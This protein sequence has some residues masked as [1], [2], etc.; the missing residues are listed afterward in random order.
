MNNRSRIEV[1]M[2][3][4]YSVLTIRDSRLDDFEQAQEIRSEML[5]AL[6]AT[7]SARVIVDLCNVEYLTSVALMP[8]V[9]LSASARQREGRVVL[10]NTCE[11]VTNVLT[12]SQLIVEHRD[13]AKYLEMADNLESAIAMVQIQAER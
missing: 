11:L 1:A 6:A 8:F 10:C 9:N 12:V 7:E 3:D 4:S 5:D 13:S 2:A